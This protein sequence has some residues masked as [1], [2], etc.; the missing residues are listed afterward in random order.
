MFV[1]SSSLHYCIKMPIEY[2]GWR[3]ENILFEIFYY[4]PL[5]SNLFYLFCSVLFCSVLF[6]SV[7]F[8]SVSLSSVPFRSVLLY[9]ALL[10]S[11]QFYFI[12][13]HTSLFYFLFRL[14]FPNQIRDHIGMRWTVDTASYRS[15]VVRYWACVV[16]FFSS[17]G[18]LFYVGTRLH[19]SAHIV[20]YILLSHIL[21]YTPIPTC[22]PPLSS[23]HKA[24]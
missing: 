23:T 2:S 3:K 19:Y 12:I 24:R 10:C 21:S 7:L 8:C 15:I 11:V 1:Y 17:N 20:N 13:F 5:H 14:V 4:F 18:W 9:S 16:V 22:P 6:C